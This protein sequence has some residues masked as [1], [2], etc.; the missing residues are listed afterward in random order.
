MKITHPSPNYTKGRNGQ[1]IIGVVCHIMEGTLKGTD[2]WFMDSA[3]GVSAHYGIGR[4]GEIHYYVDEKNTAWHAGRV[5]KP[6]WS[7]MPGINPNLVTIGIEHEGNAKSVWTKAQKEASASLVADICKRW[8]IVADRNTIIGHYEIDRIRRP[9]CPAVNKHII[10][11]LVKM[12]R[13]K[14]Y[15]VA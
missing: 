6:S 3:S 15:G 10:G 5:N 8:N 14:L 7:L 1:K 11:E 12:V 4:N 2:Y 9:N 13:I